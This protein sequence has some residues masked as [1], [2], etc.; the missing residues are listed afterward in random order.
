MKDLDSSGFLKDGLIE[1]LPFIEEVYQETIALDRP[2]QIIK[3]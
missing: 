1:Q 3:S 2:F